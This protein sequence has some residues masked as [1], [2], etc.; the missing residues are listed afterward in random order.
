MRRTLILLVLIPGLVLVAGCGG[1]D[2]ANEA[3]KPKVEVPDGE[4]P[5]ELKVRDIIK[6]T[7][8]E[9]AAGRTVTVHYVGVA[10]SDKHEFDASWG[11]EPFSVRLGQDPPRVIL[12]WE[13]GLP[14][15][16]VGGRRELIIPPALGYREFGQGS[17]KPNETLV[18]VVDLLEVA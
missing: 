13:Q 6:G 1:D 2:A 16:K 7:G 17:I 18:F 14:G 5:K 10:W 3:T 8:A 12:G 4:P 11:G 9:A 15:M